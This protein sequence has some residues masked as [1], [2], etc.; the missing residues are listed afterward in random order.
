MISSLMNSNRLEF[1]TLYKIV[2][3]TRTD[4][5]MYIKMNRV[6]DSDT[7]GALDLFRDIHL[8]LALFERCA[9]I[10]DKETCT[11]CY[12]EITRLLF[13]ACIKY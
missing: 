2:H 4:L 13:K 9:K 11:W 5:S 8:L 7:R 6:F 3:Y 1:P 12:N 10:C